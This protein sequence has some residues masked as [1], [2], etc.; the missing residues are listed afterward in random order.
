MLL[1]GRSPGQQVFGNFAS[2]GNCQ[3]VER[4]DAFA[5]SIGALDL[6]DF[7]DFKQKTLRSNNR[8]RIGELLDAKPA[9]RQKI[10]DHPN[11]PAW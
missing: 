10:L 11:L 7:L 6:L 5:K 9:P 1:A 4:I 3:S 8:A 2:V